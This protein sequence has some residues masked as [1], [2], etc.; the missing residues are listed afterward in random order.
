MSESGDMP[1]RHQL[2]PYLPPFNPCDINVPQVRILEWVKPGARV[3]EFGCASGRLSRL[4]K[5]QRQCRVIGVEI[6]ESLAQLARNVCDEVIQAD[7]QTPYFWEN[8]Q[9][10]VD[11]VLFLDVLEHLVDP[12]SVLKLTKK[13]VFKPDTE[14]IVSIPNVLFWKTRKDFLLGRFDY[15]DSGNLDRTHLRFF[16]FDTA[17]KLVKES[18]FKIIKMDISWHYPLLRLVWDHWMKIGNFCI[19]RQLRAERGF[20]KMAALFLQEISPTNHPR[21][22]RWLDSVLR[23]PARLLPGLFSTHALFLARISGE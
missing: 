18:G 12:M 22:V 14:L 21:L 3:L 23:V 6:D 17:A 20:F 7:I 9:V 4:L 15:S 1:S 19:T 10:D 13:M 11:V 5:E 8:L 16:T 2:S